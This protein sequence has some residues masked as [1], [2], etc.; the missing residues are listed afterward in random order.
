MSKSVWGPATWTLLHTLAAK[1]IES[2]F[3]RERSYLI[4]FIHEICGCLPCPEC[5]SHALSNL[6][7]AKMN[8]ITTKQQLIDFLYEF[9]NRV[10]QQTRKRIA[11]KDILDQYYSLKTRDVVNTFCMVYT[12]NSKISKLMSDNFARQLLIKRFVAYLK[13]HGKS[14]SS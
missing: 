11:S 14:F 9:H 8:M 3:T 13:D 10:N 7:A 6:K 5:R 2:E 12:L 1:V 4:E